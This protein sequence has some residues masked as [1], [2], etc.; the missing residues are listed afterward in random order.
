[1]YQKLRTQF[2]LFGSDFLLFDFPSADEKQNLDELY[3][4]INY[5][6]AILKKITNYQA[7]FDDC[8]SMEAG[9]WLEFPDCSHEANWVSIL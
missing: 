2:Q 1:L 8:I 5:F 9:Y 4:L 3:I 7:K 6:E